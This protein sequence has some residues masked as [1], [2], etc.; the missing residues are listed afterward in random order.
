[1][2][3]KEMAACGWLYGMKVLT[4][5]QAKTLPIGKKL[6]LIGADKYGEKSVE[7]GIIEQLGNVRSKRFRAESPEGFTRRVIRDYPGKV[8]AVKEGV[9]GG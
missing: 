7:E 5:E 3:A 8:W 9:I 4:A 1:M 2:T 6:Y